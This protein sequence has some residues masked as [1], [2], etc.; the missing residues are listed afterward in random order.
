V[1]VGLPV[2]FYSVYLVVVKVKDCEESAHI[3]RESQH[4]FNAIV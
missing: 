3:E 4:G 2:L 1:R